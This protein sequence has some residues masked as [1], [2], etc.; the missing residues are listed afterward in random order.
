[1]RNFLPILFVSVSFP[2]FCVSALDYPHNEN[3]YKPSTSWSTLVVGDTFRTLQNTAFAVGETLDYDVTYGPIVAG[4]AT[5]YTSSYE[6]FN[7]RKCYKVEFTMRSAKFFDVF[8]KVRD[9]YSSLIDVDGLFPWK[10]EQ[11]IREGGYKKDFEAWFD[12]QHHTAKTSTGGPYDILPYTQDAVSTFFFARTLN[13]DT[14]K[15]GQEVQFTNFYENRVYPL[16]VKYLGRE[17]VETKAGN[18]HCQ[19]IE[20]VIVEGGLFKNTGKIVVWITDD[21]LKVPVK[22]QTQV[23]IGSVAAELVSYSGLAGAM[24]A[25]FEE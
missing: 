8:F 16:S 23:I 25:K 13:Y 20:P 10:F 6:S 7:D 17:D 12:Q 5:I 21:S 15:V 1:M 24:T 3:Y 9:Y 18:F 11:H 19:K 4:S 2:M 22:V 14:M